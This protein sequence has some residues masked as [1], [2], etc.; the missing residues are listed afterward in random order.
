[1]SDA[2]EDIEFDETPVEEDDSG[3]SK[4]ED[5]HLYFKQSLRARVGNFGIFL[6]LSMFLMLTMAIGSLILSYTAFGREFLQGL[7]FRIF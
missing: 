6:I 5:L 4:T 7:V 3:R 1:M 2:L